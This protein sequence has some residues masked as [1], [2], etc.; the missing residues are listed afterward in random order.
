MNIPHSS[1]EPFGVIGIP[2]IKLEKISPYAITQAI[3]DE[4]SFTRNPETMAVNMHIAAMRNG[5]TWC[6][7]ISGPVKNGKFEMRVSYGTTDMGDIYIL[8]AFN[9]YG[10]IVP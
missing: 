5:A 7:A 1:I 4:F 10:Q 2:L 6:K 3:K 8:L 9:E